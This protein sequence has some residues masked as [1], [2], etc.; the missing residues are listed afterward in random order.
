M[1]TPVAGCLGV[2][3]IA[4]AAPHASAAGEMTAATFSE[5]VRARSV[6]LTGARVVGDVTLGS[7]AVRGLV[8]RDCHFDGNL[9]ASGTTFQRTVDLSGSD[10]AGEV[11]L[12]GARLARGVH[13][14]GATFNGIVNLR[15]AQVDGDVDMSKAHFKAQVVSGMTPGSQEATTKFAADVDF[16]LATFSDLVAFEN[17]VFSD[18]V[19]FTLARF[20]TDAIFAGGTSLGRATFA[21]AVFRGPADFTQF[22]FEGPATFDGAQFADHADFGVTSFIG[23]VVFARARFG[24]GATFVGAT[25]PIQANSGGSEDSFYGAQADGDLNFAFADV[26]RPA[27][28]E[29]V[30]VTGTISFS[31]ATLPHASALH[32][33][34][35]SASS[36]DMDV[37]AAMD[38]VRHDRTTDDRP[39]VLKLI[40]SSA[41]AKND[42]ADANDAHY[43][44]QVLKSEQYSVPLR[45]L[46]FIFYRT[47]AGYFVRPFRPLIALLAIASI[48]TLARMIRARAA[49]ARAQDAPPATP[50]S[51][52]TVAGAVAHA[53]RGIGRAVRALGEFATS[54]LTT[55]TL[56]APA[57]KGSEPERQGRQIEIW[58]YR[59]LFACALIGFANSNPTLREMF[60]AVR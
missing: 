17:A 52:R 11:D 40:E 30:V 32:F 43:A 12:S 20:G 25:F 21:R 10:F 15:G 7:G 28:F 57:R 9:I 44:R 26:S 45:Q 55:L 38:A 35:V 39:E 29:Y 22:T 42:L 49:S 27:G 23:R 5:R 53:G 58:T 41:K 46:D 24:K 51:R 33:F 34:H 18:N 60:D 6:S 56:I 31:E 48:F 13:A 2:L 36:F 50:H 19:D 47:I 37:D 54:L 4:T 14:R 1:L 8:C 16:S 3:L 59:I